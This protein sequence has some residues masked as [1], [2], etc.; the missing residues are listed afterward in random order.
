MHLM[1]RKENLRFLKKNFVS[2]AY[3]CVKLAF[4]LIAVFD[5]YYLNKLAGF[6]MYEGIKV[7]LSFSLEI[8]KI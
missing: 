6:S 7:C 2:V 3:L 4:L 8:C 5:L 1:E